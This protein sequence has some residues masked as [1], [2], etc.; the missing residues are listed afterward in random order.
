MNCERC[1]R[2]IGKEEHYIVLE[3]QNSR[4]SGEVVFCIECGKE[5]SKAEKMIDKYRKIRKEF[6]DIADRIWENNL[7][8]L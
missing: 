5:M 3:N 6:L 8:K 1:K 7:K 4:R 2:N